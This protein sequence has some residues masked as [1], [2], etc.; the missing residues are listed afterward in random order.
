MKIET[1]EALSALCDTLKAKGV[2]AFS[3]DGIRVEFGPDD[4]LP[5]STPGPDLDLCNCGCH[6]YEHINGLCAKGCTPEKCAGPEA[7]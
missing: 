1:H 4:S 5:E 6:G 2:R 3:V 7:K